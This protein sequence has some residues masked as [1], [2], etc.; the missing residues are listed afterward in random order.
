MMQH[1]NFCRPGG[2]NRG[3]MLAAMRLASVSFSSYSTASSMI[4]SSPKSSDAAVLTL[5]QRHSCEKSSQKSSDA[6][7][8]MTVESEGGGVHAW[9][10]SHLLLF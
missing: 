1:I 4:K 10:R 7:V 3:K 8:A 2:S 9:L 5:V 6:A